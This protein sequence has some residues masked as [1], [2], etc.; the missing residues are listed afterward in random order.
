MDTTNGGEQLTPEVQNEVTANYEACCDAFKTAANLHADADDIWQAFHSEDLRLIM[1]IDDQQLFL[2]NEADD[3]TAIKDY[4][5]NNLPE[6][7]QPSAALRKL[8]LALR[9]SRE[10]KACRI[11]DIE[12][13]LQGKG[14]DALLWSLPAILPEAGVEPGA[15]DDDDGS[16]AMLVSTVRVAAPPAAPAAAPAAAARSTAPAMGVVSGAAVTWAIPRIRAGGIAVTTAAVTS[17]I[18]RTSASLAASAGLPTTTAG[19]NT[20]A[21][22]AAAASFMGGYSRP[23]MFSGSAIASG[24]DYLLPYEELEVPDAHYPETRYLDRIQISA[25]QPS[26]LAPVLVFQGMGTGEDVDWAF[27]QPLVAAVYAVIADGN[28][29]VTNLMLV[30]VEEQYSDYDTYPMCLSFP[31]AGLKGDSSILVYSDL[32]IRTNAIDPC[33]RSALATAGIYHPIAPSTP[34]SSRVINTVQMG[35]GGYGAGGYAIDKAAGKIYN[36]TEWVPLRRA[37][38]QDKTKIAYFTRGDPDAKITGN[39]TLLTRIRNQGNGT[40]KHTSLP[41]MQASLLVKLLTMHFCVIMDFV[42]TGASRTPDALHMCMF[43]DSPS[44]GGY[45]RFTES[46]EIIRMFENMEKVC[47]TVFQEAYGAPFP[48]FARCFAKIKDDLHD[49]DPKTGI[50]HLCINYQVWSIAQLVVEWAA[51]YSNE[52]YASMSQPDF[53]ALNLQTLS[54]NKKQ[55]REDHGEFD[56][57]RIPAQVV[58]PPGVGRVA[59][60]DSKGG[61]FTRAER[62]A[63][64]RAKAYPDPQARAA[65]HQNGQ[66]ALGAGR[67]AARGRGAGRGRGAAPYA[68]A[69]TPV[70][71]V[72]VQPHIGGAGAKALKGLGSICLRDTLHARD[73]AAFPTGCVIERETGVECRH[74]HGVVLTSG[75]KFSPADKAAALSSMKN[76]HGEFAGAA[77]MY[78]ESNM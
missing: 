72:A 10:K 64:N 12:L 34:S 3:E 17:A 51:L 54:I 62:Q 25:L 18:P 19:F 36:C 49:D 52:D 76:M 73:P 67:G 41:V 57:S 13:I 68:A 38:H 8:H 37:V 40:T 31:S 23:S 53:L 35:A 61:K 56:K 50:R 30:Y 44:T 32:A 78:I 11:R 60:D 77:R 24:F 28:D 43:M 9:N 42:G 6:G 4:T 58:A 29:G 20:A 26:M 1:A 21:N 48:H 46:N 2:T 66:G 55:W 70:P 71:P 65:N 15:D 7:D 14:V 69:Y 59:A 33:I 74:R 63:Y 5:D 45:F 47:M 39:A 75:G 27:L 16:G 22:Q